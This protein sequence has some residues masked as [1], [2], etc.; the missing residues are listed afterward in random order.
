MVK[1]VNMDAELAKHIA[2]EMLDA[3]LPRIHFPR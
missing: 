1:R 2:E 3:M